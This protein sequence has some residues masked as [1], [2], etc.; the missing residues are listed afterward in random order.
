M[1]WEGKSK[2]EKIQKL[3]EDKLE[4]GEAKK[5]ET[6]KREKRNENAEVR[7]KGEEE[8]HDQA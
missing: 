3:K 6:K 4:K 1:K 2:A 5:S 7:D 8:R